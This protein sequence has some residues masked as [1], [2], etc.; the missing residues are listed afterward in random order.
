[1]DTD[2]PLWQ[3]KK[4]KLS[5][6]R[7]LLC[8]VQITNHQRGLGSVLSYV[9]LVHVFVGQRTHACYFKILAIERTITNTAVLLNE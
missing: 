3:K 6:S 2:D 7:R 1:M 8:F 4:K 9:C 5:T